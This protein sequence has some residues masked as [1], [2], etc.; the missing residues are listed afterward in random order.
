MHVDFKA[1]PR[2]T[3][4]ANVRLWPRQR[5]LSLLLSFSRRISCNCRHNPGW[6]RAALGR[7]SRTPPLSPAVIPVQFVSGDGS[8]DL[9]V[10]KCSPCLPALGR[11]CC[12]SFDGSPCPSAPSD[13]PGKC[14]S[15]GCGTSLF[16]AY[17]LAST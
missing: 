3:T 14:D 13:G 1:R 10:R 15:A 16:M 7:Q 12:R 8:C 4:L 6:P 2:Q 9:S 17:I 11:A 5:S